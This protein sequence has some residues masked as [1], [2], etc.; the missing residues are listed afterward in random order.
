MSPDALNRSWQ[1][2]GKDQ[3]A[4]QP[5][6]AETVTWEGRHTDVMIQPELQAE[7]EGEK[8]GEGRRAGSFDIHKNTTVK[9]DSGQRVMKGS[10]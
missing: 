8:G 9:L 1:T 2:L 4:R 7:K 6:T 5:D 3:A 10:S